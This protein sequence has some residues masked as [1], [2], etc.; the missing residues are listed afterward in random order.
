[1]GKKKPLGGLICGGMI[2]MNVR[3]IDTRI[4]E[5]RRQIAQLNIDLV[6]LERIRVQSGPLECQPTHID[7]GKTLLQG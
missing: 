4:A 5:I 3:E 7:E 6:A 2:Q 1:M